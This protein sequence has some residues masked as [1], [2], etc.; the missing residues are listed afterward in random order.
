MAEVELR[1]ITEG[2]RAAVEALAVS[3]EQS[4]YVDGVTASLAEAARLPD[5][6]PWA[7]ALYADGEPVGFVLLSD[8]VTVADPAYVGPYFLWRLLVD[9]RHQGRGYG[10]AAVRLVAEHVRT[11]PDARELL[12]STVPGPLSP[13]PFYLRQGFVDTGTEHEGERVLSLPLR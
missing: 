2:N 10:A 7:R 5:A 3:P 13:L 9:H 6:R 1:E 4:A 11:R 12:T 8:G